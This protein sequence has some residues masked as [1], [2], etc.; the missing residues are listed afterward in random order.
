MKNLSVFLLLLIFVSKISLSFFPGFPYQYTFLIFQYGVH[1]FINIFLNI[2]VGGLLFAGF[3]STHQYQHYQKKGFKFYIFLMSLFLILITLVQVVFNESENSS[4]L[5]ILSALSACFTIYLYGRVIPSVVNVE[6]FF[7][8][9]KKTSIILCWCSL[10]ALIFTP[11]TSFKGGRF[12]GVFKHIPYMVTLST[13]ACTFLVYDLI[14]F[15][16][17]RRY[18]LISL[19]NFLVAFLLLILTGTRSALFAVLLSYFMAIIFFPAKKP[20]TQFLKVSLASTVLLAS[21]LF[22]AQVVDYTVGLIRGEN[23]IGLRAAQDGVDSR[24]D[25]VKRGF[26]TFSKSPFIGQGLLSKYGQINESEVGQY[27]ANKDPHNIFVS[28][29]VIGGLGFVFIITMGLLGLLYVCKNTIRSSMPELKI[30]S[31]YLITQIPILVIYHVHLSL[32]GM[33]DRLY[34]LIIGYVMIHVKLQ[35]H[36][37]T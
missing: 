19:F 30:L 32:G 10:I 5:Q 11:G 34:W 22:G 36:D 31:I 4:L 1:P 23:S 2:A 8:I 20:T 15:N 12:I 9:I 18:K 27:N 21:L 24:I 7:K 33:A 37:R 14:Y 29:G 17:T 16:H 35:H 13:V 3:M 28:A 6:L 26:E 25:E